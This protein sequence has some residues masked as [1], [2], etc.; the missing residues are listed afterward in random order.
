MTIHNFG[1]VPMGK[2]EI[3]AFFSYD[4]T[5]DILNNLLESYMDYLTA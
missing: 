1:G 2:N 3:I 5:R 4:R